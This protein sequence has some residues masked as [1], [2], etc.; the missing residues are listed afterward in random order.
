MEV[1]LKVKKSM[2]EENLT[3]KFWQCRLL[4]GTK[5]LTIKN[6]VKLAHVIDLYPKEGSIAETSV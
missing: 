1:H 4:Q 3:P 5:L 6:F 2:L